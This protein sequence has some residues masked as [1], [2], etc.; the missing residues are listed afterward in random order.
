LGSVAAGTLLLLAAC[1]GHEDAAG[2]A[3]VDERLFFSFFVT[4]QVGLYGVSAGGA[5]PA[6]DPILG[7]GGNFGGLEGADEICTT[8]ARQ[9]NRSDAKV[10]RAFLSTSGFNGGERVDAIDRVGPGP[11]FDFNGRRLA[12]DVAG[13][14]PVADVGRPRG[15]DPQLA[16]MFSDENGEAVRPNQRVNNHDTL[17]GSGQDGR[18]FDDG[19]NG[20]VA[21]CEDWT[22]NSVHG[23]PGKSPEYDG[24]SLS[25]TRGRAP[26]P[27]AS[28][29]ST[30][31]PS[32]AVKPASI[33]TVMASLSA[34]SVWAP[35]RAMAASTVLRSAPSLPRRA[36]LVPYAND[37]NRGF[38]GDR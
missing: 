14:F 7:F 19:A 13:L 17:T 15:A 16:V 1:T 35:A 24:R 36:T 11:W 5:I 20:R 8:L 29:G 30:R 25:D 10:W 33:A 23:E 9:A 26:M 31:T 38:S 22:S 27:S 32:M 21:T 37:S 2:P 6:H 3:S 18:L 4:S 12:N 28:I 34:I